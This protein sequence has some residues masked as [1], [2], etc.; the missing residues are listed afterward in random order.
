[1]TKLW[2][3]ILNCCSIFTYDA[4]ALLIVGWYELTL[5]SNYVANKT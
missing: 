3:V 5:F 2:N 1:M 4:Y